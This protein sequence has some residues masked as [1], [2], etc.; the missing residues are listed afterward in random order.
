MKDV[1]SNR[2]AESLANTILNYLKE[3]G[4]TVTLKTQSHDGASAMAGVHQ[5][6]QKIMRDSHSFVRCLAQRINLV[7]VN[8]CGS[9][10]YSCY[11]FNMMQSLYQFFLQPN[12]H[13]EFKHVQDELKIQTPGPHELHRL[14]D[15]RWSCRAAA[16]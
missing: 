9:N 2:N 1:S 10:T 4:I 16:D 11:F 5:G 8:A 12:T 13:A 3:I 14:S 7:L 6:L 15:T